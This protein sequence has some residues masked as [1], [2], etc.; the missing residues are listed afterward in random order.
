MAHLLWH[1]IFENF[2][3]LL[4]QPRNELPVFGRHQHIDVD[5]R[6]VHL[7]GI[8]RKVL[9]FPGCWRGWWRRSI[10]RLL[11]GY[12]IRSDVVRWSPGLGRDLLPGLA[13]ILRR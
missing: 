8:V 9:S 10:F 12:C 3:V 1:P 6:S 11:F 5:Q 13:A 2:E 4:L 7:Q